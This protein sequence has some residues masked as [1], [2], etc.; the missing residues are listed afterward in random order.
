MSAGLR[1]SVLLPAHNPHRDRLARTVAGLRA[2]TL[3]TSDWELVI[4]D[5]ASTDASA[6]RAL[7]LG[8]H[9][10]PRILVEPQLGL[11]P[12]RLRG[13]HEAQGDLL[14]FVDDDNVLAP[15]YLAVA[16]RHFTENPK[17]GAAG[18]PIEAEFEQPPPDW[19]GEFFGL[20]AV[21][22]HGDAPRLA[23]GDANA[24]WPDFAPVGAGLCVRREA[25][26]NYVAALAAEPARRTLDR[27]GRSLASGGDSDFVFTIL[28]HGWTV[29]YFPDLR[30]THLIPA[31]RLDPVYLARLNHDIQRTWVRVLALH[32]QCPWKSIPPWTL[33]LR[34]ARAWWREAAWRSPVHRIR[35]RGLVGRFAGQ[36]DLHQLSALDK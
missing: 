15:D 3:P 17:L 32:G 21:H 35:W 20:L 13:I 28:H 18:G 7:D 22:H 10:T 23:A 4:L 19:A 29:G 33:P 27:A 12:A 2:Q 16:H 14:V 5:N 9:S 24:G 30:L 6:I 31:G 26:Q 8:W 25:A 1:I 34:R 36:A 11:T